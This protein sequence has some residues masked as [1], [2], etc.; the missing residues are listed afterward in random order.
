MYYYPSGPCMLTYFCRK[1][2]RNQYHPFFFSCCVCDDDTCYDVVI[3]EM[4]Y[5]WSRA[6]TD[7]SEL[8][9]VLPQAAGPSEVTEAAQ[10]EMSHSG[11]RKNPRQ[12]TSGIFSFFPQLLFGSKIAK[13]LPQ[14]IFSMSQGCFENR[15]GLLKS[16]WELKN[17]KEPLN[18]LKL[19]VCLDFWLFRSHFLPS[20]Y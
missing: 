8:S 18:A 19:W 14:H 10:R 5:V 20:C 4:L 11:G 13:Y 7:R 1:W 15:S 6:V 3:S 16:A 9:C 12:S 17:L 2:S